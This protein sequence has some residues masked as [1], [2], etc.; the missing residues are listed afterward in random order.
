[1]V[2]LDFYQNENFRNFFDNMSLNMKLIF[3]MRSVISRRVP[4]ILA[5]GVGPKVYD[6]F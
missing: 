3:I 6:D 5:L 2:I 1:M 4:E